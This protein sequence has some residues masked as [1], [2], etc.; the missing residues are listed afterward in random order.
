M[1]CQTFEEAAI[2]LQEEEEG[3]VEMQ[4]VRWG[5]G[6]EHSGVVNSRPSLAPATPGTSGCQ[7]HTGGN[8]RNCGPA[9]MYGNVLHNC[10][11]SHAVRNGDHIRNVSRL[12]GIIPEAVSPDAA[13]YPLVETAVSSSSLE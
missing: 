13:A 10:W 5:L 1:L 3:Q 12:S 7:N 11:F 6:A 2:S 8:S 4:P 9:R